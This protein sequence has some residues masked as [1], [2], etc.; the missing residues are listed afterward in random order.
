MNYPQ[1]LLEWYSTLTRE[2]VGDS[3]RFYAADA[4]F[5]DPFNDVRG[6]PAIEAIL[7]HMFVHTG[8]PRFEILETVVQGQQAFVTWNFFFTLRGK[9]YQVVGGSHFH[10][11]EDGLVTVHRDYWDAAEE[12]LQK[13]PLIGAPI[14]WLRGL[15]R[16][17]VP[18]G[19]HSKGPQS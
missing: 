11:N 15:F 5:R 12:L 16:I 10:F 2:T 19:S 17:A 8:N 14:R 9:P 1:P 7:S 6:L 18:D 3:G 13:L 4:R